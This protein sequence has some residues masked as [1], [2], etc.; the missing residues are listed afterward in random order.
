MS[1]VVKSQSKATIE[2]RVAVGN[3][4]GSIIIQPGRNILTEEN[5]DS[6]KQHD[7]FKRRVNNDTITIN[8]EGS[9]AKKAAAEPDFNYVDSLLGNEDGKDIIKEYALAWDIKL[10][11]KN[12]IENLIADFKEQYEGK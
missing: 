12:T 1:V 5:Y 7:D 9:V 8:T 6:L 3:G 10:N 2:F 4:L 11:K